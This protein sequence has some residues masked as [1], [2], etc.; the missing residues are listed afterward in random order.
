MLSDLQYNSTAS[1]TAYAQRMQLVGVLH[2]LIF[3]V[4]V[5]ALP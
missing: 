5:S 1:A 3:S 2:A 4:C